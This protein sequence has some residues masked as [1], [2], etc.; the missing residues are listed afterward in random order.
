[1]PTNFPGIVVSNYMPAAVSPGCV[2][3]AVASE[4]TNVGHY[5][6]IVTNDGSIV[7]Y[8]EANNDEIYDFKV[9][10]NGRLH[11]APFVEPHSYAGGGDVV[12]KIMDQNY[13]PI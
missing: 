12:H 9:L 7:W 10:P 8:Q 4:L 3:L 2:F 13:N 5:L 1:M 6:M 11:Y